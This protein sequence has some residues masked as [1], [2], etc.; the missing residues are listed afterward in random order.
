M[1]TEVVK[2]LLKSGNLDGYFTNHRLRRT[3][4]MQLFQAGVDA[5][6]VKEVTGHASD[7][8]NKYQITSEE[9]KSDVSVIL[10]GDSKN[11]TAKKKVEKEEDKAPVLSLEFLVTDTSPKSLMH[12]SCKHK[13][14][15]LS[16]GEELAEMINNIVSERKSGTAKIKLEIEF[17]V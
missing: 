2:K 12:C 11:K 14:F 17:S 10:K 8:L 1:L 3:S 7:A 15:D 4:A 9:Q 5:K 16:K 6:I 13:N